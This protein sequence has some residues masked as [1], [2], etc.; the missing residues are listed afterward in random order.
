M[1]AKFAP[2]FAPDSLQEMKGVVLNLGLRED[3]GNRVEG[4]LAMVDRK[5][6][7]IETEPV[8][9]FQKGVDM[10]FVPLLDFLDGHDSSMLVL[11]RQRTGLRAA[12]KDFVKMALGDRF[13][14]MQELDQLVF[15]WQR[16][17]HIINPTIN[18]RLGSR[19]LNQG[20]H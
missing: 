1:S 14:L 18:G 3:G 4:G 11:E 6:P 12:G 17:S 2:D 10:L 20:F 5:R 15:R 16:V 7:Q 13:L 19:H 8:E 9:P